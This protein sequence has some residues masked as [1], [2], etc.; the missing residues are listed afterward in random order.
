MLDVLELLVRRKG[1]I[2]GF[3]LLV[4]AA[5]AVYSFVV[6]SEYEASVLV[7]P[8]SSSEGSMLKSIIGN[9]PLGKI[10]GLEAITKSMPN[11]L[12]TLYMV[13]LSSR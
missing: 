5:V 10:G 2:L 4:S 6:P 7:M 13:I 1:L 3:S 9:T 12:S 8:P 11:D